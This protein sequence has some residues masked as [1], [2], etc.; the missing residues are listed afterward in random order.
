MLPRSQWLQMRTCTR[1]C[2]HKK[3]RAGIP[4]TSSEHSPS[5]GGGADHGRGRAPLRVR[6]SPCI[7]ALRTVSGTV[8]MQTARFT[9]RRRAQLLLSSGFYRASRRL[10]SP[11]RLSWPPQRTDNCNCRRRPIIPESTDGLPWWVHK[12][13]PAPSASL[14]ANSAPL[15]GRCPP[16]DYPDNPRQGVKCNRRSRCR[17]ESAF[18]QRRSHLGSCPSPR[19]T[20]ISLP[21][22]GWFRAISVGDIGVSGRRSE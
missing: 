19:S 2:T 14:R 22:P 17:R 13:P 7:R 12:A 18:P 15:R 5:A 16:L 21:L 1:Q 20:R 4:P 9:D 11:G 8:P 3:S 6:Q 10:V